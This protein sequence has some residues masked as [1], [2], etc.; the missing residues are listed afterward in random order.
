[1][2]KQVLPRFGDAPL[3]AITNGGVR[4]WV[5]DLLASGLSAVTTRKAVFA[6][7]QCLAAAIADNRLQFNPATTIPLPDLGRRQHALQPLSARIWQSGPAQSGADGRHLATRREWCGIAAEWIQGGSFDAS[8]LRVGFS[9]NPCRRA[10]C[11]HRQ[12]RL[13]IGALWA[14]SARDPFIPKI[15]ASAAGGHAEFVRRL[16]RARSR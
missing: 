2:Q 7:R 3:R 11:T 6:L 15:T 10:R 12:D 1:M 14:D 8:N 9:A 5:S 4:Q 16:T 13:P